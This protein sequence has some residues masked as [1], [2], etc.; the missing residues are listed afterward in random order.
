MKLFCVCRKCLKNFE[1]VKEL[2][3]HSCTNLLD[4]KAVS[5]NKPVSSS[6][7]GSKTESCTVPKRQAKR[8]L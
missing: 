8:S 2:K 1:T 5:T 7:E 4:K 3:E 6:E